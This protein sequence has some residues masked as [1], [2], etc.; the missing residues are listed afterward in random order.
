MVRFRG[1]RRAD[2]A[3]IV[4][5]LTADEL[6]RGREAPALAPYLA[7]FDAMAAEP[8]NTIIVG[9]R[10]GG[11][12]ATLQLTLISGLSRGGARRAQVEAVRVAETLRGQGIGALLMAEAEAR[13]RAAGCSLI[14][15][16]SDASRERAHGFYARL[17]YRATH[18]GFKRM[19]D[20]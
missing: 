3:G 6:G 5:L 16:T 8:G 1:A 7:A 14:Q 15:F 20:S 12:V 9:E 4:A 17:G 2:V 10:A 19:L 11:I 18:L 13:A